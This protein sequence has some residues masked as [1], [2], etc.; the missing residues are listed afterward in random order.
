MGSFCEGARMCARVLAGRFL[1]LKRLL[2]EA[3]GLAGTQVSVY[4][5]SVICHN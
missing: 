2:Q 1:L 4:V 3:C 5:A